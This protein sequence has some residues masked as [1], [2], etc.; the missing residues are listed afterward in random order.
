MTTMQPSTKPSMT[1]RLSPARAG[2]AALVVALAAAAGCASAPPQSFYTLSA[3]LPPAGVSEPGPSVLVGRAALPEIVDRPQLVVRAGANQVAILEQQRWAEPLRD[4]IPR[5][6]AENLGQL[7]ATSEVSTRDE[8]I[9]QPV[10]RVSLDVRR[11]EAR[12]GAA[13]EVET[14][15]TVACAGADRRIGQSRV[16][17]PV[18]GG[19]YGA[20]VVAQGR[21]LD[22]VSR[23]IGQ[24]IRE[25]TRR[26]GV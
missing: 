8:V 3:G 26:G 16:R 7:L 15:W 20:L 25:Q 18:A 6:V 19:G 17:Q 2:A 24:A 14:L 13:V 21:A 5:V 11:F 22:A 1:Q 4:A 10:C 23:D 9:R 12:P